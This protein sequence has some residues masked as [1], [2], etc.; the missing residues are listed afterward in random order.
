MLPNCEI[1]VSKVDQEI[2]KNG[3]WSIDEDEKLK[4]LVEIYGVKNWK[5]I[6][7]EMTNRSSIQC[8]HRWTK[9][10]QPGL[11]KGPWTIEEDCILNKWV[12]ENGPRKWSQ[13]ADMIKGRSGKQC[14]ER[15]FNTLNPNVKKGNWTAKED[16]LIFKLFSD[17]GSKWSKISSHFKGRTENSIKN[18]FYSTLRRISAEKKRSSESENSEN[19][20]PTQQK[21]NNSLEDL[22][23]FFPQAF[24]E[25]TRSYMETKSGDKSSNLDISNS[26]EDSQEDSHSS[27]SDHFLNKKVSRSNSHIDEIAQLETNIF[28]PV[29]QNLN[30]LTIQEMEKKIYETSSDNFLY[31]V[32]NTIDK[33]IQKSSFAKSLQN[34]FPNNSQN[35]NHRPPNQ[36]PQDNHVMALMSQLNQLETIL[37]NTKEMLKFDHMK[38]VLGSFNPNFSYPPQNQNFYSKNFNNKM[39]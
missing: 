4:S 2:S 3:K 18:R 17:Y 1:N 20:S 34:E 13:C 27:N 5:K 15:W 19:S 16:Y 22:L 38:S 25:K 11:V 31:N 39:I 6:S 21:V 36:Q 29:R 9:I 32:E 35:Y 26:E 7:D 33:K 12:R 24:E 28:S 14:R 8:L 37:V 23:K 30:N 10:L